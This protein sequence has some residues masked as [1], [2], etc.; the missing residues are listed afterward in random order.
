M[1]A[2]GFFSLNSFSSL[3]ISSLNSLCRCSAYEDIW[4]ANGPFVT[5]S[6]IRNVSCW[7]TE[8][9]YCFSPRD[10]LP[11]DLNLHVSL[12]K[13]ENLLIVYYGHRS[14][15]VHGIDKEGRLWVQ[16]NRTN[17]WLRSKYLPCFSIRSAMKRS[18]EN[19][20]QCNVRCPSR[21]IPCC[22]ENQRHSTME[23]VLHPSQAFR[24]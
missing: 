4:N 15:T 17:Q 5:F 18:C 3:I 14:D 1:K 10:N 21:L 20:T 11:F 12:V 9:K 24:S 22:G 2:A 16:S 6:W 19:G 23:S 7:D 13:A 8:L